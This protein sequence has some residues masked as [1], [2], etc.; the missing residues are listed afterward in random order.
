MATLLEISEGYRRAAILVRLQLDEV[1]QALKTASEAEKPM[2]R[3]RE[4][5]LKR[6]LQEMRDLRDL[7]AN[8]YT[9]GRSQQYTSAGIRAGRRGSLR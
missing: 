9:R 1:R 8:Y 2:L 6:M 4:T 5:V 3:Q 7:T